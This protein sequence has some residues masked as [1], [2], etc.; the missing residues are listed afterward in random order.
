MKSHADLIFS[1]PSDIAGYDADLWQAMQ[2]E[3]IRQEDHIELIASENYASKR[4]LEA[5]G[6]L[7]TNK[8]AEGYPDKRYYGGCEFVDV[9]EHLQLSVLKSFIKLTMQT[10][11]HIQAHLQMLQHF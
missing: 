2:D 7:L 6:S 3:S 5:Q 1:N 4:V 8:Y 9:A 11:N 10:F